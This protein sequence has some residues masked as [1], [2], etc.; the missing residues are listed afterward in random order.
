MRDVHSFDDVGEDYGSPPSCLSCCRCSREH[1]ADTV[2]DVADLESKTT[3]VTEAA[4]MRMRRSEKISV[5]QTQS[6]QYSGSVA[7]T[8]LPCL[9]TN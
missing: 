7:R 5:I 6:R 4:V 8:T 2:N 9:I 1:K 3:I